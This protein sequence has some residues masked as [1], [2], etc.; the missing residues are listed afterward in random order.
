MDAAGLTGVAGLALSG[1]AAAWSDLRR[2]RL[3]NPLCLGVAAAG[4]LQ[5]AVFGGI[6]G[7]SSAAMHGA[8]ALVAGALLF[9]LGGFGGGDAKYY[10]AVACWFGLTGAA[11]LLLAVSLAGGVLALVWL[12]LRRLRPPADANRAMLPFGVAIAAG[13]LAAKLGFAG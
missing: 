12:G 9:A 10:A 7:L 4:L 13:A 5:A 2:R 1:S 8:A 3:S 6:A 11:G